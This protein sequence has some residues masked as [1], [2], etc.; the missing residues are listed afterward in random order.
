MCRWFQ[1]CMMCTVNEVLLVGKI[2]CMYYKTYQ[3]HYKSVSTYVE[4]GGGVFKA[5]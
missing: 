1:C 5:V 3:V 2:L 4:L